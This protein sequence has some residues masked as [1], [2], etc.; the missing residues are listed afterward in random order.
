[1]TRFIKIAGSVLAVTLCAIF[2]ACVGAALHVRSAVS[3]GALD[4]EYGPCRMI[5]DYQSSPFI[6]NHVDSA[7]WR[8]VTGLPAKGESGSVWR[9]R[10]FYTYLGVRLAYTAEQRRELILPKLEALPICERVRSKP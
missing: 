2:F 8:S 10:G 7:M 4:T 9:L 3:N 6:M 1:M 5:T